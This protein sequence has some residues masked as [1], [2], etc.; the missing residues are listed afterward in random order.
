[1]EARTRVKKEAIVV[2]SGGMDSSLCLA[3][4][5]RMHGADQTLSL[6][7]AKVPDQVVQIELIS[8]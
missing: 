6:A 8:F 1:M 7:G 3:H 5:I 4:A 2:H